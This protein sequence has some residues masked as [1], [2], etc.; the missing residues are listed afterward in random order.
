MLVHTYLC[1]TCIR[2]SKRLPPALE[3][4]SA[5]LDDEA[6]A[7]GLETTAREGKSTLPF[8]DLDLSTSS[9]AMLDEGEAALRSSNCCAA[10]RCLSTLQRPGRALLPLS[11]LVARAGLSAGLLSEASDARGGPPEAAAAVCCGRREEGSLPV[12]VTDPPRDT[13][14][15]TR[16]SPRC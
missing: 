9:K 12:R 3:I 7:L 16:L 14:A 8:R 4:G 11:S 10:S 13:G 15:L 5:G 2:G 6:P 1:R